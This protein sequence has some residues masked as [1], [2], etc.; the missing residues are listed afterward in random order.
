MT[1][2]YILELDN[3]KFYVGKTK[4]LINRILDHFTENGSEWTKKYKPI[5]IINVINKADNFEEEKQTLLLMDKYGI[6]NVRGG[7]YC[8][9]ELSS[10]DKIKA[11][12]QIYSIMDKCYKCGKVGH[13]A[14]ECKIHNTLEEYD[15]IIKNININNKIESYDKIYNII[16]NNLCNTLIDNRVVRG[17]YEIE[18]KMDYTIWNLSWANEIFEIIRKNKQDIFPLWN[19]KWFRIFYDNIP[20]LE[21]KNYSEY[22]VWLDNN[23]DSYVKDIPEELTILKRFHIKDENNKVGNGNEY[24]KNTKWGK[25]LFII[26]SSNFEQEFK[27][28]QSQW[29]IYL[30]YLMACHS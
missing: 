6:N 11:Q 13:F 24:I 14:K 8:S 10:S 9:I 20:L 29:N 28:W 23:E 19:D 22:K 7:S 17:L 2:I 1:I 15:Y 5:K 3:N 25:E 4:N 21:N 26:D 30:L 16:Q 12:Q 18:K 27:N